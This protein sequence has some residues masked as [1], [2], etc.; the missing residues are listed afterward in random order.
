MTASKNNSDFIKQLE[1]DIENRK[2]IYK[3]GEGCIKALGLSEYKMKSITTDELPSQFY[4]GIFYRNFDVRFT[5]T[6]SDIWE[7]L[8]QF[9][10]MYLEDINEFAT[11]ADDFGKD[12]IVSYNMDSSAGFL[13]A[14]LR[15]KFKL[16]VK[17]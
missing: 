11:R 3:S 6:G 4:F 7:C 15:N 1:I 5:D 8:V 12:D 14:L 16:F 2:K 17:S 10:S 9:H 13:I